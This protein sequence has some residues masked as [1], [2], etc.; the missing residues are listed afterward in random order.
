MSGRNV[1]EQ[2]DEE[3]AA[4]LQ[5]E[6][7]AQAERALEEV[8]A[9]YYPVIARM[10]LLHLGEQQLALDCTQ[11]VMVEIAKSIRRFRNESKLSTWIYSISKRVIWKYAR[12][13][14]LKNSRRDELSGSALQDYAPAVDV[15]VL[16]REEQDAILTA[17]R[18]LPEKQRES[19][20]LFYYLD[21][22]LEDIGEKLSCSANTVKAH[23]YR[24]R[25]ALAKRLGQFDT[26]DEGEQ[27]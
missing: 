24:A 21:Y 5:G 3:L 13:E 26:L 4:L 19:V 9:R 2:T 27:E 6:R 14:R 22:S 7:S 18:Q 25:A 12:G 1:D 11:E 20:W 10:S 23:L 8:L 16:K 15:V 17:I